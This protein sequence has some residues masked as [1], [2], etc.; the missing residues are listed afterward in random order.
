MKSRILLPGIALAISITCVNWAESHIGFA[1]DSSTQQ[2]NRPPTIDSFTSSASPEG[3]FAKNDCADCTQEPK[4]SLTVRAS[5]PDKD[6]LVYTYT[7]TAGTI[8]GEGPNTTWD[9]SDM[10]PGQY[11][12]S[13]EVK[14]RQ[15]ASVHANQDVL[16]RE[17]ICHPT[18]PTVSVSCP[19][20]LDKDVVSFSATVTDASPDAELTWN[21][22]V[23]GGEIV[24]GQGTANLKVKIKPTS[25]VTATVEVGGIHPACSR[26]A[27]CFAGTHRPKK[28]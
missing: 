23:D 8:D 17:C 25:A 21:W 4:I 1:N 16:V 6:E 9:L 27:S 2:P 15:G 14:D 18:C 24:E 3:V 10:P 19:A 28:K 11:S 13:V 22:S 7:V 5:D 20:S 26:A 12:V